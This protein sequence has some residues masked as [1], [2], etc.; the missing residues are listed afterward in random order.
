MPFKDLLIHIENSPQCAVRLELAIRLAREHDAQLTGLYVITHPSYAPTSDIVRSREAE[1]MF[2]R[3][4]EGAGIRAEWLAADWATVGVDAA[5]VLKSYAYS[6]DLTIIGQT[7]PQR[8]DVANLPERV[9]LGTG[10][11]VLIVPFAGAYST[12]GE[13]VIVA[14]KEGRA[15]ARAV[16]DALPFLLNAKEVF[17]LSI[18]TPKE[19]ERGAIDEECGIC[20]NLERHGIKVK[21]TS[22]VMDTIPVANILMNFAWENGCDLI[23]MGVYAQTS[24][25]KLDLG[26]VAKGFLENMTLSVLMSH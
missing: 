4:T 14:W 24:R 3:Q 18:K 15:S 26:P 25:G 7:E 11:P 12:V 10:R 5:E 6:R 2:R 23:V 13:R 19:V 22:I 17:V 16:N 9:V 21:E 1:E 8:E 20:A